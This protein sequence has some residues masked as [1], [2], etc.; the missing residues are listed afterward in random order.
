VL[1]AM[2]TATPVVATSIAALGVEAEPGREI[3]VA[4]GPEDFAA[5][6]VTLLREPL[7]AR[8]F[9]EAGRA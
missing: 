9:G 4:D 5:A 8:A 3:T 2:A 7:T 6:V 1:E